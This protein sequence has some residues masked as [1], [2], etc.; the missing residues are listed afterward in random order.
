MKILIVEDDLDTATF[1]AGGLKEAGYLVEMAH[2]GI[3][4]LDMSSVA[5]S[6]MR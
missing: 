3:S 2:D 5:T 1:L 6:L 4:G